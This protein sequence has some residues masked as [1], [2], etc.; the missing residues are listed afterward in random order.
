VIQLDVE[1]T[2]VQTLIRD[3]QR[4]PVR[5]T[6]THVDFYEIHAGVTL[7][8]QVPLRLVGTSDGVRN[9]GG[10][11]EQFMREVSIEV[12]PRH[13]PDHVEL[14][15]TELSVGHS[16]HISDLDIPDAKILDDDS[17]T[18]CTVVP[19]RVEAEPTEEAEAEEEDAVEPELIRK[20]READED[21]PEE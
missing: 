12:L 17:A 3:I 21:T 11:L 1:G 6:V 10:I 4:H 2:E 13:L 18:V 15:V 9:Q 16:L 8:V 20:P 14:D 5:R 19:P 7:T